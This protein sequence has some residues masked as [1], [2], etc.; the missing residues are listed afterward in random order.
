[1]KLNTKQIQKSIIRLRKFLKKMPRD[2]APE[3]VHKVRT[4]ARRLG[5]SLE[6]IDFRKKKF[7]K[8]LERNLSL[9]RKRLGKVRDMDV[10]TADA[11]SVPSKTSD[12]ECMVQLLEHLG[13]K[14]SRYAHELRNTAKEH[15]QRLRRDLAHQLAIR[16]SHNGESV[17]ESDG[18]EAASVEERLADLA[19]PSQLNRGNLHPYRLKVKELR[20]LLQLGE[21]RRS[22]VVLKKLGE[23]KDVI[24]DW[25][26]WE[27]LLAIASQIV[28]GGP[29]SKLLRQLKKIR[30]QKFN[31]ALSIAN[32]T[33]NSYGNTTRQALV[34]DSRR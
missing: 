7:N 11:M 1:M 32:R 29:R 19:R 12:P 31:R 17:L 33:R 25:H 4:D 28:D 9:M 34:A 18:D 21:I 30:D 8:R 14:S 6:T 27:E 13:A 15:G 20:Y 16:A 3:K 10:L 24:G 22:Q 2:P 26:D 23:V 5:T